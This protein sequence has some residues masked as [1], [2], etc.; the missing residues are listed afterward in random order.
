VVGWVTG[1]GT[2]EIPVLVLDLRRAAGTRLTTP[3]P[4]AGEFTLEVETVGPNHGVTFSAVALG[5]LDV[6]R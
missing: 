5:Y 4:I 2:S 1:A 3:V 6:R